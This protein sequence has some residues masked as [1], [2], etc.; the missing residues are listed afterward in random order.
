VEWHRDFTKSTFGTPR[1]SVH[2]W[3]PL[4][5]H[6]S[7]AGTLLFVPGSHHNVRAKHRLGAPLSA[8][9]DD[10]ASVTP[11]G[12]PLSVGNFSIHTPWTMH[13]SNANRSSQTRK[14]M[15]FEFSIGASSA[16]RQVGPALVSGL[17]S[18]G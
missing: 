13:C 7:N 16:A 18:R 14:A 2:F 3:I 8:P 10:P 12:V 17:L 11:V 9:T 1:R 4:N 5:N 6:A 15:I